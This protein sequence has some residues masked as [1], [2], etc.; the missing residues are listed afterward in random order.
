MGPAYRR[1]CLEPFSPEAWWILTQIWPCSYLTFRCD[2]SDNDQ[3]RLV[4]D[5]AEQVR[6][7]D[8][9][10]ADNALIIDGRRI[11]VV[12]DDGIP[13][14]TAT[15]SASV[16]EGCF[17]SDIWLIPMSV[18]GGRAVTFLEH[19][20]Y[21]NPSLQSALTTFAQD[22]RVEGPWITWPKRTNLCLQLQ[23]K[24]EPRLLMRTPWLAGR[25]QN[26]MYCPETPHT[27]QPFPDDPYFADGGLTERDGPSYFSL[28]QV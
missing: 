23:T 3:A 13:E 2:L 6:M 18:V 5:G 1:L 14:L 11:E 12:L 19:M 21:N 22:V 24:I 15:T 8:Q 9:L 20:D 7:R 25:L 10:R 4:I 26:V 27:R 17:A 16:T 28:W